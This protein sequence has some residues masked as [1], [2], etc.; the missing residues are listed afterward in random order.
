MVL[1]I[2]KVTEKT[3]NMEESFG[4]LNVVFT[5]VSQSAVVCLGNISYSATENG[6]FT[7][8]FWAEH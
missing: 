6:M 8:P 7:E 4:F 1:C 5:F 3:E 2:P